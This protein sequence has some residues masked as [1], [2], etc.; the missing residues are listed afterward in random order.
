[1]MNA[2][3]PGAVSAGLQVAFV[4]MNLWIVFLGQQ[5]MAEGT[6]YE[7]SLS[8]VHGPQLVVMTGWKVRNHTSAAVAVSADIEAV[9]FA[10][11]AE[12]CRTKSLASAE[13]VTQVSPKK[14]YT[15]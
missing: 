15:E 13:Q 1:M 14:E 11:E 9:C 4:D 12:N 8:S 5:M 3:I 2:L 10:V 6:F 7:L